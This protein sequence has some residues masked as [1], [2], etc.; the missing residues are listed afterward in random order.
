VRIYFT[1]EFDTSGSGYVRILA[2]AQLEIYLGDKGV[3]SG[4][5]VVNDTQ[6]AANCAIYGLPTCTTITYSGSAQYIG[7]VYAPSAA[8]TFSGGEGASGSFV[9]GSMT[10]SGSAGVHYDEA[11][12]RPAAPYSVASW[13]E[14]A[15]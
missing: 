7:T 1:G 14:L 9:A 13:E 8:F 11:L 5:G 4:S 10:L 12:G 15:Q 6:N 3:I 2:G